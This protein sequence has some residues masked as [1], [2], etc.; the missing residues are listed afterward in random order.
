[1]YFTYRDTFLIKTVGT[2]RGG[3]SIKSLCF[4][5]NK[6]LLIKNKFFRYE[7]KLKPTVD[8][9]L[10]R[11]GGCIILPEDYEKNRVWQ[12]GST[13]VYQYNKEGKRIEYMAL[14]DST[15]LEKQRWSYYKSGKLREES[16]FD[17]YSVTPKYRTLYFYDER[18][19]L[20]KRVSYTDG[21]VSATNNY[22][23]RKS[24]VY[25]DGNYSSYPG[26]YPF[27][28]YRDTKKLDLKGRLV[29]EVAYVGRCALET[30]KRIR[31]RPDG[32][33][34]QT[35]VFTCRDSS[36]MVHNYVYE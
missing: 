23:Y 21:E 32:R 11:P 33:I 16:S 28:V 18:G 9:G 12:E 2:A 4:Y 29:E 8:K 34:A 31:Y 27:S 17:R 24:V 13:S 22:S 14:R 20:S 25:L 5:N 15:V 10:G 3:D 35:I 30:K 26:E 19:R 1:M 36:R 7:K 6:G